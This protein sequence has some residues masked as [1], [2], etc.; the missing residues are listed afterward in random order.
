[1]CPNNAKFLI[2]CKFLH[3]ETGEANSEESADTETVLIRRT[4][5]RLT[6]KLVSDWNP[7]DTFKKE[8]R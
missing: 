8:L 7:E 1:M 2:P 3:L 6:N 5:E 4:D